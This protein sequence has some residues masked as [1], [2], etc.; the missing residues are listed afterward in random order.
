M[1]LLT[2]KAHPDVKGR[3]PAMPLTPA[4]VEQLRRIH[5]LSLFGEL[6][7]QM[8]SLLDELRARDNHAELVAPILDIQIIP[9]QLGRDDALD[10]F[11]EY[12]QIPVAVEAGRS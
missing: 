8:Q 6:P 2:P 10:N 7:A 4:E 5:E 9:P 12:E 3:E 1:S 11:D